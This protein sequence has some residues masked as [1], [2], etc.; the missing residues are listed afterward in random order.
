MRIRGGI[1]AQRGNFGGLGRGWAG[2][3]SEV[4]PRYIR[5]ISGE[6]W[7]SSPGWSEKGSRGAGKKRRREEEKKRRREEEKKRRREEEK[8]RR[9][10]EKKKRRREEE[11]FLLPGKD[12][13]DELLRAACIGR[14]SET[15]L[16]SEL[17]D[18]SGVLWREKRRSEKKRRREDSTPPLH[19]TPPLQSPPIIYINSRS[20]GPAGN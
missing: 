12:R 14:R 13:L 2:D 15:S 5:G 20:P 11:K 3:I 17:S 19:S 4:Y 16:G 6:L 18:G 10:E 9:E 8:K 7:G 1:P